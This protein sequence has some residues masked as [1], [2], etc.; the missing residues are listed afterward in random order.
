MHDCPTCRV[1]LHGWEHECPSCGTPQQVYRDFPGMPVQKQ[2]GV[3][4]V[5]IVV[6]FVVLSIALFFLVQMTWIGQ[7]LREGPP[8]EDPMAKLTFMDARQIIETKLNEGL[9]AVAA[10]NT[11]FTWQGPGG[12]PGDKTS[13]NPVEL[14]VETDLSAAEQHK[15][16]VDPVKDY[17]EKAKMPTLTMEDRK[18]HATWT[19]TVQP[20]QPAAGEGGQGGETPPQP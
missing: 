15:A 12:T 5:P 18:S 16:I 3:N 19:Y 1:P 7:L 8:K 13:P 4:I 14:K 17:M 10:K 20:P 6:T 2:P 11:K 9:N